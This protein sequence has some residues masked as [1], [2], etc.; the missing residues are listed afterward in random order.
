MQEHLKSCGS[1]PHRAVLGLLRP[2]LGLPAR[3]G[4]IADLRASQPEE[5]VE[6]ASHGKGHIAT[7]LSA[8]FD[9][10]PD[11]HAHVPEDLVLFFDEIF[12]ANIDR[13]DRV[14]SHLERIGATLGAKGIPVIALKGAAELLS[15]TWPDPRRRFLSDVDILVP[16]ADRAGALDALR[17]SYANSVTSGEGSVSSVNHEAW[18]SLPGDDMVVELHWALGHGAMPDLP[19]LSRVF[20]G[21]VPSA[22]P[23][24]Q[25]PSRLDRAQ[26]QIMHDLFLECRFKRSTNLFPRSLVDHFMYLNAL[27][28]EERATLIQDFRAAS[29]DLQFNAMDHLVRRVFDE[30]PQP[31]RGLAERWATHKLRRFGQRHLTRRETILEYLTDGF[32]G[33]MFDRVRRGRGAYLKKLFNL[34]ALSASLALLR[35]RVRDADP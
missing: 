5:I 29:C 28:G 24:I 22:I 33:L 17:Q 13:H 7:L 12:R 8:A 20:Q 35:Q 31:H 25:V 6:A 16:E 26:H 30:A 15:P 18:L 19:P 10:D 32:E 4:L 11:L 2:A 3:D 21:A 23:G 34:N 27:S 9:N 1:A 14:L